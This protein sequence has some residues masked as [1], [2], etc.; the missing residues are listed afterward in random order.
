MCILSLASGQK[1]RLPAD[2]VLDITLYVYENLRRLREQRQGEVA[3][4]AH[5][6]LGVVIASYG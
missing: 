6:A 2:K 3:T 5:P 1:T 4:P